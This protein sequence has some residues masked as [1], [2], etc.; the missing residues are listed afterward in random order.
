MD[1]IANQSGISKKTL[2]QSFKDKEDLINQFTDTFFLGNPSFSILKKDGENA[3]DRVLIL[4]THIVKLNKLIQNNLAHD[5]KRFYPKIHKKVEEF[6]RLKIY[7]DDYALIEQGKTEGLFREDVDT[8]FVARLTVGRFLL[9]FNPDYGLFSEEE[10]HSIDLFDKVLDYHFHGI[11][12]EKG[13]TYF[14]QQLIK[15]QHE[16]DMPA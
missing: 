10:I 2:Y 15:V 8:H 4:R 13:I 1:E 5:L 14:K 7:D 3:I 12:T 11:C 16:T 6:K 9:L